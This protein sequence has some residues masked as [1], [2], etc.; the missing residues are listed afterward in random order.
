MEEKLASQRSSETRSASTATSHRSNGK[1]GI[2][3]NLYPFNDYI[4][5]KFMIKTDPYTSFE[6]L[7]NMIRN[8][9]NREPLISEKGM[10]KLKL[11]V[12][13]NLTGASLLAGD[14]KNRMIF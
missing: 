5:T 4:S 2:Q 10:F 12:A 7:I 13:Q 14:E 8:K 11:K 3:R 6:T 1:D 9:Y